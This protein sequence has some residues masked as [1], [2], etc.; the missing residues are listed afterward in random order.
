MRG[1][2]LFLTFKVLF[3][4]IS[5][6]LTMNESNNSGGIATLAPMKQTL[7]LISANLTFRDS[8]ENN[9]VK[10]FGYFGEISNFVAKTI[11]I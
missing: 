7:L 2:L 6:S 10:N 3:S 11:K 9:S 8:I 1:S 5:I 4:V